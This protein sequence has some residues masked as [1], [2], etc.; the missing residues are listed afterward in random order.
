MTAETTEE[1]SLPIR[2]RKRGFLETQ[3]D[4]L[5][6]LSQNGIVLPTSI[7]YGTRLS[8]FVTK[9][10]LNGLW[11][12]GLVKKY[13]VKSHRSWRS[14]DEHYH[15]ISKDAVRRKWGRL[16]DAEEITKT[17]YDK[18]K[19]RSAYGLTPQGKNVLNALDFAVSKLNG[20]SS[21]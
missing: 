2:N 17:N 11:K 8:N 18:L 10:Y 19:S 12:N 9:N 13:H 14:H 5:S 7:M 3:H 1:I 6:F 15:I 20:E 16:S 4:I 21:V